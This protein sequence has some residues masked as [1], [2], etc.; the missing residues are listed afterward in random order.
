[1]QKHNFTIRVDQELREQIQEQ[2]KLQGISAAEF[3]R[4]AIALQC[5]AIAGQQEKTEK[6]DDTEWLKKQLES[7][8]HAV[9]M[10]Q[11]LALEL[12]AEKKV[13]YDEIQR[14]KSLLE[15]PKARL[16]KFLSFLSA[17][18]K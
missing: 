10:G 11:R 12:Q 4:K 6:A 1:M 18:A 2:A 9:Q 14:Q 8:A 13:L 17:L 15:Q 3:S 5:R 7:N 16:P